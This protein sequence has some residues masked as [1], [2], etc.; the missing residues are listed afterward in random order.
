MDKKMDGREII[1]ALAAYF[2]VEPEFMEGALE[3]AL[4]GYAFRHEANVARLEAEEGT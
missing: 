3:D 2:K 1:A 4:G